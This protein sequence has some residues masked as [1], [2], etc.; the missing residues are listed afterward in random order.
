[1]HQPY[2]ALEKVSDHNSQ[3]RNVTQDTKISEGSTLVKTCKREE[4]QLDGNIQEIQ[5]NN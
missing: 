5:K 1:M 3:G 2:I 4:T